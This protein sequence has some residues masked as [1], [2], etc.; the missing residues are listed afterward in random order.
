VETAEVLGI[1]KRAN[2]LIDKVA[3]HAVS[4]KIRPFKAIENVAMS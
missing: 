3:A 4:T 2:A 1:A